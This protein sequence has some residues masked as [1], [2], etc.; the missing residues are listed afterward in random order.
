MELREDWLAQVQ[1]E[2]IDPEREIVDPHHHLWQRGGAGYEL[3]QL[4]ADTQAG[5]NVVQTVYIE[6]RS[7]YDKSGEKRFAPVGEIR[8]AANSP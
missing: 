1:E 3:D 6:C 8:Y 4:R 7:Y 2:V 5:H